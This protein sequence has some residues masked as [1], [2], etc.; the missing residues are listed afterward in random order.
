MEPWLV[1]VCQKGAGGWCGL[2][3]S[4][5]SKFKGG[6][7]A[8]GLEGWMRASWACGR[9][10][11]LTVLL[12]LAMGRLVVVPGSDECDKYVTLTRVAGYGKGRWDACPGQ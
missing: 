1:G 10:D 4:P 3:G 12:D 8:G 2:D 5:L 7:A 9:S 11:I 6:R